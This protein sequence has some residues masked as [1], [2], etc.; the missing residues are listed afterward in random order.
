MGTFFKPKEEDTVR[1]YSLEAP[2]VRKAYYNTLNK[3][4]FKRFKEKYPEHKLTWVDF[5][6]IITTSNEVITEMVISSRDG[7]DLPFMLG[8]IIIGACNK[9]KGKN[10]DWLLSSKYGKKIINKNW[11]SNQYLCKIFFTKFGTTY[12]FPLMHY[13]SFNPAREFKRDVSKVFKLN[14]NFYWKVSSR[15]KISAIER[16]EGIKSIKINKNEKKGK[17]MDLSDSQPY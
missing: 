2:R 13:W 14:W 15:E 17:R 6:K 11:E 10:Y 3:D 7:V 5:K 8:K 4:L 1:K 12:K 9:K 16:N